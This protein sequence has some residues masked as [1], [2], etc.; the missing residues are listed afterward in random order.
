MNRADQKLIEVPGVHADPQ[1]TVG[2]GRDE[3]GVTPL[4]RLRH[5][6]NN[7]VTLH[8]LQFKESLILQG[9]RH[10]PWGKLLG[11]GLVAHTKVNDFSVV[12]VKFINV[13]F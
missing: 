5:W 2:F 7:T 6:L 9:K 8:F 10:A 12:R 3:H 13:V 4:G 11:D 1:T